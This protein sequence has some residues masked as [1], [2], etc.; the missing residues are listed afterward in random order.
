MVAIHR[1]LKGGGSLYRD[2]F[3]KK[4]GEA[5]STR[6]DFLCGKVSCTAYGL[7]DFLIRHWKGGS[8]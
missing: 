1:I 7:H 3:R 8:E 6:F 5:G 2:N 4:I